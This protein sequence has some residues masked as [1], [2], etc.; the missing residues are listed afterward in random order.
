MALSRTRRKVAAAVAAVAGGM[1]LAAAPQAP[2]AAADPVPSCVNT[3]VVTE[4]F[5]HMGVVI[6]NNCADEQRAKPT[7]SLVFGSQP[8]CHVLQPGQEVT[9]WVR[10][11]GVINKFLGLVPC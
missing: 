1:A 11:S 8:Q 9:Q 3:L 7:F 2:A 5:G 10:P 6:T 4:V